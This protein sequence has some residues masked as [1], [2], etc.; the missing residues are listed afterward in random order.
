MSDE[1]YGLWAGV[2]SALIGWIMITSTWIH[3]KVSNNEFQIFRKEM[4]DDMKGIHNR[5]DKFI[6]RRDKPRD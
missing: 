6:E 5:L 4:R 3:K 2:Y 1:S